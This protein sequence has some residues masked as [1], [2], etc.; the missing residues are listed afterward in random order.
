MKSPYC[1]VPEITEKSNYYCEV[2]NNQKK[3][4]KEMF[5]YIE[6]AGAANDKG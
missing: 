1:V 6:A 4:G 2:Q 5:S 3:K